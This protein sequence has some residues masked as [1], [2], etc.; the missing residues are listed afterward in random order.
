M[1]GTHQVR[2]VVHDPV[3]ADDTGAWIGREG[4]D[5]RP[6]PLE[7]SGAGRERLVDDRDLRRVNGELAG[8]AVAFGV[9]AFAVFAASDYNASEAK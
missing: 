4:L 1:S 6:R 3:N 7:R 2:P 9:L 5:N 8:K